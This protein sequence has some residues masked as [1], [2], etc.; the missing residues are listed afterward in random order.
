MRLAWENTPADTFHLFD[1]TFTS[2]RPEQS[3][4]LYTTN[5]LQTGLNG[6]RPEDSGYNELRRLFDYLKVTVQTRPNVATHDSKQ[7]PPPNFKTR[8]AVKICVVDADDLL[9]HPAAITEA[10]CRIVGLPYGKSR[11][12]WEKPEHR[13]RAESELG[14]NWM[15]PWHE[16][17]LNS[18][19]LKPRNQES[20]VDPSSES[21]YAK[22]IKEFGKD[23]AD[24]IQRTVQANLEDY[25]YLKQFAIRV[26]YVGR[27][28]DLDRKA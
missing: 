12:H 13:R 22:W 8:E 14:G 27:A 6:Y 26:S 9:D 10:Y 20:K 28:Y 5:F 7:T 3:S 16:V 19:G 18:I 15:R 11:P 23:G 4:T 24:I 21:D 17:A 1:Q 2:Q 25:E